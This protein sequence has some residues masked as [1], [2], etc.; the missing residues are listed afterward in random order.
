MMYMAKVKETVISYGSVLNYVFRS[1]VVQ[2]IFPILRVGTYGI[3]FRSN[4]PL[5]DAVV[6]PD[7]LINFTIAKFHK[8]AH[9]ALEKLRTNLL[10]KD[11]QKHKF[12]WMVEDPKNFPKQDGLEGIKQFAMSY[13][14]PR[15]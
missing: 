2:K 14:Y 15:K 3:P 1:S 12:I 4:F 10:E 7:I 8:G 5:I 11:R 9:F 13:A 6:Q